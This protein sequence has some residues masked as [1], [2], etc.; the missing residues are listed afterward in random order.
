MTRVGAAEIH[1][2]GYSPQ[3]EIKTY[4]SDNRAQ[5]I[6]AAILLGQQRSRGILQVSGQTYR[7]SYILVVSVSAPIQDLNAAPPARDSPFFLGFFCVNCYRPADSSRLV[8]CV[9]NGGRR[10]GRRAPKTTHPQR[11]SAFHYLLMLLLH[12]DPSRIL[13]RILGPESVQSKEADFRFFWDLRPRPSSHHLL[14]RI[15]I[16]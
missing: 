2:E 5:Q 15:G 9:D 12:C 8:A 1:R 16:E 10:R 7:C 13:R 4:K 11:P 14:H 6:P 3:K